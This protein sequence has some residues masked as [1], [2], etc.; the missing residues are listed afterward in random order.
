MTRDEPD[1]AVEWETVLEES[2]GPDY[3]TEYECR[4]VHR[5]SGEVVYR[6]KKEEY[7]VSMWGT[8]YSGVREVE[9][10][11]GRVRVHRYE[12]ETEEL[13]LPD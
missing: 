11:E 4:V 5:V 12:G 8:S 6:F 9:V 3:H 7:N 10:V 2:E 1:Y 13:P